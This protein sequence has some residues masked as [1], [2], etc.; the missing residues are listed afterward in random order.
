M[1]RVKAMGIEGTKLAMN[2]LSVE[3][4]GV[5]KCSA[6]SSPSSCVIKHSRELKRIQKTAMKHL[7]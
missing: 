4:A 5:P 6:C 3:A 2:G 1:R 7:E